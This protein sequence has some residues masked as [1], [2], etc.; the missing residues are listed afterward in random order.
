MDNTILNTGVGGD[1]VRD[2]DRSLNVNPIPAKTQVVQLDAGGESQ[3]SLVSL[4]N[5]LPVADFTSQTSDAP[6]FVALA[7]DPNGDFAGQNVLELVATDGSGIYFNT[8]VLNHEARDANNA[9]ILSDAKPISILSTAVGQWFTI[10][11]SG[12]S[13]LNLT[14]FALTGSVY[15]SNDLSGTWISLS[16]SNNLIAAAYTTAIAANSTYSF[17]CLARYIRIVTNTAGTATAYLRQAPWAPGYTTPLPSNL[18]QVG[19]INVTNA[20][21]SGLLAVGGNIAP[22]TAPTANPVGVSGVDASSITRRILT[23][24]LGATQVGGADQSLATHRL[25][26][27]FVG[28]PIV[29]LFPTTAANQS[30]PELLYQMLCLLRVNATYLHGLSIN[31]P[32]I[33]EPDMLLSDMTNPATFFSNMTN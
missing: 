19:G 8:Q 9:I 25:L 24:T 30:I 31:A 22:G 33:E 12:Y 13:S 14:T 2:I 10:D 23:D 16:G 3:E 6:N 32:V 26:T 1:V 5:P 11:T 7:G 17:P 15:S 21:V 4:S 29:D 28:S 18:A 20:G 27:N